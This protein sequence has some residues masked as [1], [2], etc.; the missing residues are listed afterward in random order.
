[1]VFIHIFIL[2]LFEKEKKNRKKGV[3]KRE[4]KGKR[5]SSP[6]IRLLS[7]HFEDL[8]LKEEVWPSV[9][10]TMTKGLY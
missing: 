8:C 9:I 3:T 10:Q 7:I 4:K 5:K 1:M 2:S 6:G